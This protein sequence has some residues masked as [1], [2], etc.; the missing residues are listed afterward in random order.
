MSVSVSVSVSVIRMRLVDGKQEDGWMVVVKEMKREMF[1]GTVPFGGRASQ[2]AGPERVRAAEPQSRVAGWAGWA[3]APRLCWGRG[4]AH[5][6]R[7]HSCMAMHAAAMQCP[8]ACR[9][10]HPHRTTSQLCPRRT[11]QVVNAACDRPL[12]PISLSSSAHRSAAVPQRSHGP[13][14]TF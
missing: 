2:A 10:G 8:A 11:Q 13:P 9:G 14:T 4:G 12:S 7:A 1:R 6:P 3:L 5:G